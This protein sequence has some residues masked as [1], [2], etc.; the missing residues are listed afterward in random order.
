M[1]TDFAES[2]VDGPKDIISE[3]KISVP[4]WLKCGCC[5]GV[6]LC[7]VQRMLWLSNGR[8]IDVAFKTKSCTT[9]AIGRQVIC[10]IVCVFL[11]KW[12]YR[13]PLM[14]WK[15]CHCGSLRVEMVLPRQN[16]EVGPLYSGLPNRDHFG[17]A[18]H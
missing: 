14:W 18:A 2:E 10:H 7:I 4:F 1:Y 6:G 15:A 13:W 17:S 11:F 3:G 8:M 16:F 5:Q 9:L 12:I